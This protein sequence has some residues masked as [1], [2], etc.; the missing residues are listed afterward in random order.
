M[1]SLAVIGVGYWGP[2][3]V[4]NFMSLGAFDE[5]VACDRD[6]ARLASVCQRFPGLQDCTDPEELWNRADVEAV[7]IAVPVRFHY[8]LAKA[9]LSAGKHVLIEKPMTQTA[10]QARELVDLAEAKNLTLM[11]DHTFI[12]TG[13]VEKIEQIVRRQDLG[14]FYYID[15]VRVNLGLFQHDV[16]VIWDLAPHDLS[17][18]NHILQRRPKVVRA[19]GQSHTDKDLPDVAYVNIEYG[20]SICANFHVSWLAP[21]KIRRMVFS[22]SRRMIVWNDLEDAE[23]IRVYDRGIELTRISKEQEY[24]LQVG[25]RTGDVWLPN[26]ARTE[27][28][29]KVAE[30][31]VD[32]CRTGKTPLTSGRDGLDVVM[33]LEAT[34]MSLANAGHPVAIDGDQMSLL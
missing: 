6:A 34:E 11:V 32:C 9:A 14:T 18:V 4:R 27:A 25:Y 2:N 23:K 1:S 7:V 22:G 26:V 24:E 13:A 8:D 16:N 20:D 30:H 17:I 10:E 33:T 3:L 29:R 28:L 12:Y 15:S 5:V 19:T 21:T 31:F